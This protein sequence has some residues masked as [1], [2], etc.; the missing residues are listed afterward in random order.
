M[1]FFDIYEWI[2]TGVNA[3]IKLQIQLVAAIKGFNRSWLPY[4]KKYKCILDDYRNDKRANEIL[5]VDRHQEC[6]WFTEM[7][8]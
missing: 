4:K 1:T 5:G 7:D 6:K 2:F 8:E 3:W